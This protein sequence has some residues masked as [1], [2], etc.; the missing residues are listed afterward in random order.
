MRGGYHPLYFFTQYLFLANF[1]ESIRVPL[2]YLFN[3]FISKNYE[4]SLLPHL[5]TKK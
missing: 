2:G 1:S 3:Y 4:T 5:S